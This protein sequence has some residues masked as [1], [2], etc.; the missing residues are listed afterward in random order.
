MSNKCA[1]P[2]LTEQ[3]P[4][5]PA[6][7]CERATKRLCSE[8]G[9]WWELGTETDANGV[10]TCC[11]YPDPVSVLNLDAP[12]VCAWIVENCFKCST[13]ELCDAAGNTITWADVSFP[14]NW[15]TPAGSQV[16][17]GT[18]GDLVAEIETYF[19]NWSINVTT[20][21]LEGI[22]P[23]RPAQQWNAAVC[24]E[25][26]ETDAPPPSTSECC[27]P[28]SADVGGQEPFF[29][30]GDTAGETI[31]VVCVTLDDCE[32]ESQGLFTGQFWVRNEIAAQ[33][34]GEFVFDLDLTVNGSVVDSQANVTLDPPDSAGAVA[35]PFSFSAT[36]LGQGDT[37]C[38][39][40]RLVAGSNPQGMSYSLQTVSARITGLLQCC[41]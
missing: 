7:D 28:V 3:E 6:T 26:E 5:D 13:I 35:V 4:V 9:Q 1:C 10:V 29:Q 2:E 15:M 21:G 12:G 34:G 18:R 27:A 19:A 25:L 23:C 38:V 40:A 8:H 41:G 31:D 14:V 17:A 37:V 24:I 33:L 22:N 32:C 30:Q 11:W 39:R 36:A 16:Y 20:D